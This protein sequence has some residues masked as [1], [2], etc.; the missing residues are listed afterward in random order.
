[1]PSTGIGGD[2]DGGWSVRLNTFTDRKPLVFSFSPSQV[3]KMNLKNKCSGTDTLFV[4]LTDLESLS[5]G[6][7]DLQQFMLG[8][9]L[10]QG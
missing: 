5:D 9:E 6:V 1:M 4:S 10:S 8:G 3:L 7:S 2:R